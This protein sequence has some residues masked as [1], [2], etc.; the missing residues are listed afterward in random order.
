[1]GFVFEVLGTSHTAEGP[2]FRRILWM[3]V[4]LEDEV[5]NFSNLL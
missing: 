5:E 2:Q 3:A 1:M 4:V